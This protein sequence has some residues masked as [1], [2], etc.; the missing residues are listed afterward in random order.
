VQQF[1]SE[2]QSL[3]PVTPKA[4]PIVEVEVKILGGAF[5]AIGDWVS[6]AANDVFMAWVDDNFTKA[7]L[8]DLLL[9]L[10]YAASVAPD[11]PREYI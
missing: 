7:E 9:C 6:Q 11:K 4:N 8:A 1:I 10:E 5:S 2:L 3:V